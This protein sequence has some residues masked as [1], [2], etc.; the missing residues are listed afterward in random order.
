[1]SPFDYDG[2]L[3]EWWRRRAAN[4]AHI[5]AYRNV[6]RYIH[7]SVCQPPR[8][9]VD[10]ACGMGD[11]LVRLAGR[12]PASQLVGLDGSRPLLALARHRIA[13]KGEAYHDRIRLVE[14]QLPN[15]SLLKSAADLVVFAFPNMQYPESPK[16][17]KQLEDI[18]SPTDISA[19]GILAEISDPRHT[20]RGKS[21]AE[22]R[23]LLALGRLVSLNLRRMLR[24][25]G[26]CVRVE[27]SRVR[28]DELDAT[29]L[30][31]VAYEEGSLE[32]M[33]RGRKPRQWFRVL[34]SSYFRSGVTE[35]VYQ[36]SH[37]PEDR[38]GGYWIT[39]LRAM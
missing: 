22:A 35:D 38:S 2:H 15:F 26:L 6:A 8:L 37:D 14:T 32:N 24:T 18:L 17:L 39:I 36:Q 11:L 16:S 19:A 3:G 33:V 30:M 12:F 29:D 4:P 9:I 13:H 5:A 27:Y 21:V 10:Y 34:A 20:T 28:R 1:M 25:G 7:V 23:R 31:R